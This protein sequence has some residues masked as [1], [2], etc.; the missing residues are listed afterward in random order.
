MG[1][2]DLGRLSDCDRH[3]RA[4]NLSWNASVTQ[5]CDSGIALDR[6]LVGGMAN[7]LYLLLR[8]PASPEAAV[9]MLTSICVP[10]GG[11]V[12]GQTGA[13]SQ[14]PKGLT[15]GFWD[16]IESEMKKRNGSVDYI[17]SESGQRPGARGPH[18]LRQQTT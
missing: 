9:Q 17:P 13:R 3:S 14:R 6:V 7:R 8:Q 18:G 1:R 5:R 16:R 11:R 15:V 4:R 2:T 12:I 10:A